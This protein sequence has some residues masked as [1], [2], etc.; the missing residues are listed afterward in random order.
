VTSSAKIK[1]K[2]I[3]KKR[4]RKRKRKRKKANMTKKIWKSPKYK[5]KHLRLMK[6]KI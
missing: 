5:A 2:M 6:L 4:K 3:K 1:I